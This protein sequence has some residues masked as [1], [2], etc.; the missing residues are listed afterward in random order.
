MTFGI[1]DDGGLGSRCEQSFSN[2]FVGEWSMKDETRANLSDSATWMRL[3]V[4]VLFFVLLQVATPLLIVVSLVGWIIRLISGEQPQGVIDF[5]R[6][7]AEWFSRTADY[8]CGGAQ[9]RPFPFEDHD[10]PSDRAATQ[11]ASASAT[12]STEASASAESAAPVAPAARSAAAVKTAG[13]KTAKKKAAKK[14]SSK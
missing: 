3:P 10:C 11:P 12:E 1:G 7:I 14:K 9:R 8:L 5:G 6:M 13:K 4:M 2:D